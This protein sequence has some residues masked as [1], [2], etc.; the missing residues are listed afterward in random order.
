VTAIKVV[1]A[2]EKFVLTRVLQKVLEADVII[3]FE[4]IS[5][6]SLLFGETTLKR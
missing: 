1:K 6:I 3:L 2:P 4:S 5:E